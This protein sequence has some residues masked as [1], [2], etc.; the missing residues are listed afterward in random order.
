[1]PQIPAGHLESQPLNY[2]HLRI[3]FHAENVPEA[4][5]RDGRELYYGLTSWVDD[6]IGQVLA[7]LARS[8]AADNTVV[9]YSSDHGESMAEHGLWWKS[10]MY[11]QASRVPLVIS[12]PERWKGGQRRSG[13][14]SLVD[15][16]RTIADIGG[17]RA[18][19]DWNGSSLCPLLDDASAPWKDMAVSEYYAHNIASG[20]TMIRMGQYKYVYHTA[21]D[22]NHPAQRELYDLTADPGEFKNLAAAPDQQARIAQMHSAMIKEV[23]SD[24]EETEQ[25]CRAECAK[26]YGRK[27]K[28]SGKRKGGAGDE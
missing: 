9:I 22:K 18:P 16:V 6:Q 7:A 19:D 24:P 11:Q 20:Y 3:A 25:R 4:V 5:V 28:A 12:W 27:D 1:M 10:C 17:A 2:K 13:A 26:G 21:A 23:G 8:D 15:T 14:C